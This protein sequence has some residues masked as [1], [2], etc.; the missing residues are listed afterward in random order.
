MTV[1]EAML[2]GNPFLSTPEEES[3]LS[4]MTPAQNKL[5]VNFLLTGALFVAPVPQSKLQSSAMLLTVMQT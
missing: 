5:Q 1:A 3:L 2:Q 4:T